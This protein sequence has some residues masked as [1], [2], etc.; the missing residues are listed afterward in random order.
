MKQSTVCSKIQY[1]T[2][3]VVKYLYISSINNLKY[4]MHMFCKHWKNYYNKRPIGHIG[5]LR[6]WFKSIITYD[7]IIHW[8]GEEKP[9]IFFLRIKWFLIWTN[10]NP[11]HLCA[12]FGWNWPSG[13]GKEDFYRF[14]QCIFCN[15]LS[16]E[17]SAA[18][19]LILNPFHPMMLC[20]KFNWNWRHSPGEEDF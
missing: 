13:S 17:K 18:L 5:H 9:I 3:W 15:Y 4:T 10:L 20:A 12:K 2:R 11:L 14:H 1:S 8:I 6:K 19:H 16:L 7:Y